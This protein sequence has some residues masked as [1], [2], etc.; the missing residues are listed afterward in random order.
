MTRD[1]KPLLRRV[2]LAALSGMSEAEIAAD[3]EKAFR[4]ALAT[5][6]A[7]YQAATEKG[8]P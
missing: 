1:M 6:R 3:P 7:T 5:A 4:I 2:A 8:R